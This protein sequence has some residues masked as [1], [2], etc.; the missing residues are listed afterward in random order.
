MNVVIL[1]PDGVG[2]SLLQRV[3]TVHMNSSN[4]DR[5]IINLH[6]LTNGLQ[7]YFSPIFNDFV[8][9]KDFGIGYS[10]SLPEIISLLQSV[11]HYKTSRLA[12]YHL[13]RRQDSIDDQKKFYDFL[14]D[15]FFIIA[16]QRKN[17]F[18]YGL[19]WG[20]KSTTNVA[21]TYTHAQKLEQLYKLKDGVTIPPQTFIK[22]LNNYKNY[23][24]WAGLYFNVNSFFIYE[25]HALDID[26]YIHNLDFFQKKMKKSWADL[27]G[28]DW[29]KWNRCHKLTSDAFLANLKTPMIEYRQNINSL[30]LD[31]VYKHLPLTE[32]QFLSENLPVYTRSINAVEEMV[33]N[34]ILVT[35][36]PIKMQTLIEKK[37]ITKNFVDLVYVYNDW[38]EKNGFDLIEYD[39]LISQSNSE[40]EKWYSNDTL[41][42][43]SLTTL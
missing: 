4:F 2:S 10:Q 32:Q 30:T 20:L 41:K 42:Q 12:Y 9:G 18:E 7:K 29:Q 28:L 14:N 34:G 3:L 36:I 11:D 27:T 25:D 35:N 37:L 23:I 5:S 13:T 16:A 1:T 38:A 8:L 40:L 31:A 19:N 26:T 15:N 43:L 24:Q 22:H 21:N 17:V 6:E 39:F 33:A